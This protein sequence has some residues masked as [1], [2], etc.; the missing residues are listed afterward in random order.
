MDQSDLIR[1]LQQLRQKHL[2]LNEEIISAI[3]N[4][5]EFEVLIS[6]IS[7]KFSASKMENIVKDIE[8]GLRM[9]VEFFNLDR[10]TLFSFS[11]D[12]SMIMKKNAFLLATIFFI[13]A[14][15]SSVKVVTDLDKTADFT[16]Y[17]T[18]SFLGWQEDIDKVINEFD[19]E[20]IRN[21]LKA[22]MEKRNLKL[23]DDNG[24]MVMST[25]LVSEQK[26]SM[27]AYTNYYGGGAGYGYGRGRRGR[28]GWGMGGGNHHLL[29]VGLCSGHLG[30]RYI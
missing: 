2:P 21:V 18:I 19:Q 4:K 23:V 9:I 13:A 30:D 27:T 20:R 10:S 1:E 8:D 29:R 11:D 5:L 25:F 16:K 28:G 26:T 15:C 7:A 22:E 17:Q 14:S 24:D 3:D 6:G 12:K